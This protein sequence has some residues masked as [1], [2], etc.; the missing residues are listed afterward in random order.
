MRIG[1][2]GWFTVVPP[3]SP[4][5]RFSLC[6]RYANDPGTAALGLPLAPEETPEAAFGA[7]RARL[8][9]GG[10]SRLSFV[11]FNTELNTGVDELTAMLA[12]RPLSFDMPSPR[13]ALAWSRCL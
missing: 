11:D 3:F 2:V 1:M 10:E 8:E 4:R 13:P 12:A 9:G 5:L 7:V 6:W